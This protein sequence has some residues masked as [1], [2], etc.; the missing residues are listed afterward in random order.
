[1]KILS[2]SYP[3]QAEDEKKIQHF[4]FEYKMRIETNMLA[5]RD[6]V[7][8]SDFREAIRKH[9][10]VS[11]SCRRQFRTLLGRNIVG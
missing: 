7:S 6:Q 2:I 9:K 5:E 11:I 3:K 8:F 4:L 1:M 10:G